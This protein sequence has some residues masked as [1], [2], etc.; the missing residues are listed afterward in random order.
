MTMSLRSLARLAATTVALLFTLGAL[1]APPAGAQEK[2]RL[3]G[4]LT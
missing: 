4:I 1:T 3:G 2:P